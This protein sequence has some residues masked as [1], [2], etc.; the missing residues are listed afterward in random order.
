M[1]FFKWV[2]NLKLLLKIVI[3][4]GFFFV[5]W[6]MILYVFGIDLS[7]VYYGMDMRVF[8]L[9]V[10]CVFVFV[11]FFNCFSFV[12]LRKSKVVFN[13]VGI[14]SILCFILFIVFVSEY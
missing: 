5:V 11:W 13:I 3:G 10:G 1:V 6:M 9:L 4:F 14:I 2:K 8:D 12:V 7:C